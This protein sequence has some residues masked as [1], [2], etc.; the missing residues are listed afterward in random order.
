MKRLKKGREE[1][2]SFQLL[3]IPWKEVLYKFFPEK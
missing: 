2:Y 3:Q 1:K